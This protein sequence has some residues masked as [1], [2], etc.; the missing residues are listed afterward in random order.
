MQPSTPVASVIVV[1]WNARD[2]LESCLRSLAAQTFREFE[3][4]VVDN[5]STDGSIEL[6]KNECYSSVFRI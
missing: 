5:G 3:I 2:L 6:L 4:I 1:N